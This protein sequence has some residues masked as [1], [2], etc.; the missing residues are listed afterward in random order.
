MTDILHYLKFK[1][2]SKKL[3]KYVFHREKWNFEHTGNSVHTAESLALGKVLK[4]Y[5][6]Y[7]MFFLIRQHVK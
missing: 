7:L 3:E 2:L 1:N 6:E 5:I 4:I